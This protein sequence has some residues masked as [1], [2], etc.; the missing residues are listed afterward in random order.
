MSSLSHKKWK[1]FRN[2]GIY[3]EIQLKSRANKTNIPLRDT[4]HPLSVFVLLPSHF[5][6]EEKISGYAL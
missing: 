5:E 4:E 1:L 3:P 2:L 6:K